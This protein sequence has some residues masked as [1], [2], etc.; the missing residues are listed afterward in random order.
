M[1][2]TD[3]TPDNKLTRTPILRIE[4]G[5]HTAVIRRI[6]VD[7]ANRYLVTA[8]DDKTARVWELATGQ[9]EPMKLLRVL[10]PPLGAG[11]EGKLFAVA[12]SP[13]GRT[14]AVGGWTSKDGLQTNLYLFDRESGRLVRRIA[15][16]PNVINH[17]VYS[18]DGEWLAAT[19]GEGGVRV[20]AT[21]S[22]AETGADRDYGNQ[23]YGADFDATG[24][25]VTTC[26]DG[27]LRLYDL[28][29]GALRLAAK[30][31]AEGG[32]RPFSVSFSPDGERV[33][34][35]FADSTRI[36]VLSG[37]DLTQLYAPDTSGVDNWTLDSV[38]WTAD[39]QALAAG[40][41]YGKGGQRQIRLWSEG[42]RG[43]YREVAA[44]DNTIMHILPLRDGG[45]VYGAGDPAWGVIDARGQRSHFFG[46][47]IADYRGM[48][49]SFLLSGDGAGVQFGYESGGKAP[50]RFA[51]AE[52]RLE[53]G[54]PGSGALAA[55]LITG[56]AVSDW[57]DNYAPKL[58]GQPL[59]LEQYE[60]SRSLAIA[61]DQ[62][63]F[64]LGADYRLRLF[65]RSGKELWQTAIPGV[66]WS[67]NISGNGKLA[68]AA[69]GDG[70]IRWYRLTDGQELLA[71]FPHNDRER[72]VLWTPSGYYDA[73]PGAEDLIGW[74]VNNGPE[75]ESDFFP[76]SQFRDL[77]YRPDVVARAMQTLDEAEAVRLA[78]AKAGRKR[79]DPD[80][81]K[82]LPPVVQLIAPHDGM[83]VRGTE[84][85]VYFTVRA[86]SGE[87]LTGVKALVDGR[88]V[89]IEK[90][91]QWSADTPQHLQV[92]LPEQDCELQLLAE[93]RFAASVPEV[94]RLKWRGRT[95]SVSRPNLYLL[96]AGVSR[97]ANSDYNLSFA[98]KDARDF[99]A[100]MERQQGLLYGKVEARAL[101]DGDATRDGIVDG[102]DWIW[103]AA[104]STDVAMVFLAGHGVNDARG[105]YF[106]CPHNISF[107]RLLSTG[108]SFSD[109]KSAVEAIA[110][111]AVFFIDT[112]HS[113]NALGGQARAVDINGFINE[114]TS[115]ENGAVVFAASTGR[116]VSLEFD[117]WGNGA[118][119]K[120]L[121]EGING[122]A[123]VQGKD[124]IT[125]T[126]LDLYISERVKALTDNAITG[127]KC[128]LKQQ[129][130]ERIGE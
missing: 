104:K 65:D 112:C 18:P 111:K 94:R 53:M 73:S 117:E 91:L 129:V 100:A 1:A 26:F 92:T 60:R 28:S 42:E 17:L 78:D 58:N 7:A 39:R 38:A 33:A 110:G 57:K 126:S 83:E 13:D 3:Q 82:R 63:R 114:L 69:F 10:R 44:A 47:E 19:L 62:A 81:L 71:F 15:G 97:Y 89:E 121:V 56:L 115:A 34:V 96:A 109:I 32:E 74:H 36:A 8:S 80:V 90:D 6:S 41:S 95:T 43:S 105:R 50:A 102:L 76:A 40:G 5:R 23:S 84:L 66:A 52:R 88:P 55:P 22:Y 116:Q 107:E 70:T 12:L 31:K 99:A 123:V 77:Y 25:L 37:R 75:R 49:E 122:G 27:N 14:V 35:G 93:N 46:P 29:D 67:V 2:K 119:T 127:K 103:K 128:L 30:R 68:V 16:L 106:F 101:E 86:P 120:A 124:K 125:I 20:Y 59:K 85:T 72:W 11:N 54:V 24:R 118:F 87:P 51:V 9:G 21:G 64:L 79:Q 113:G 45:L 130:K 4:T 61:P 98:A 48:L 108:V